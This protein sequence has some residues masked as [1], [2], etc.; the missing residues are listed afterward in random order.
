MPVEDTQ[1]R[2]DVA[3]SNG[4]DPK[5]LKFLTLDEFIQRPKI[6][7]HVR[8]VIP[9]KALVVVFGPPKGGKTFSVCELT[10]HAAHGIDWHGCAITRRMK[11]MYLAGEASTACACASRPGSSITIR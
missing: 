5:Q 11:V 6:S 9:A 2:I 10:M 8:G 7:S 3:K 1:K 4:H